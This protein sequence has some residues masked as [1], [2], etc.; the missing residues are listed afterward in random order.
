[1]L[2]RIMAALLSIVEIALGERRDR[3]A[4]AGALAPLLRLALALAVD[5]RAEGA[6]ARVAALLARIA[7]DDAAR[8]AALLPELIG[9][10]RVVVDALVAAPHATTP[11][12]VARAVRMVA[13][14]TPAALSA[15]QFGQLLLLAHHPVLHGDAASARS[16]A[17]HRGVAAHPFRL[18]P[19]VWRSVCWRLRGIDARRAASKRVGMPFGARAP[20]T[21]SATPAVAAPASWGASDAY[22]AAIAAAVVGDEGLESDSPRWRDAARASIAGLALAPKGDQIVRAVYDAL[23]PQFALGAT[24]LAALGAEAVETCRGAPGVLVRAYDEAKATQQQRKAGAHARKEL[25]A[26]EVE[27]ARIEK[28]RRLAKVRC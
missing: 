6:S 13:P 28:K 25:S 10:A 19:A 1:V 4:A 21:A 22:V 17:A 5:V 14:S 7:E 20:D 8:Y 2:A 3:V 24:Q 15:A 16:I 23:L 27:W 9:A 11:S 18:N 12:L 26:E